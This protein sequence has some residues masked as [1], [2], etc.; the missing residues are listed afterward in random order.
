MKRF[1]MLLFL[2]STSIFVSCS[3]DDDTINIDQSLIPGEWNLTEVTSENGKV[4]ATTDAVPVPVS[5]NYSVSS[6]DMTVQVTFVESATEDPNT[7]TSSGGFTL[8]AMVTLPLID[9]IEYEQAIPE[10]IG[11]GEW[12]V[13]GNKLITTEQSTDQS[14][15]IITLNAETISLRVPIDETV[16]EGGYNLEITG[17]QIFTLTKS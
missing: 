2:A 5:G 10:F 12:R 14:F 17:S 11:T 8:V 3:D 13:E 1:A 7:F 4:S 15:D 16:Q 6:K 9:P